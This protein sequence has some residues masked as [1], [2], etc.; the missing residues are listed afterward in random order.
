[1]IGASVAHGSWGFNVRNNQP[2]RP[3]FPF[4]F[5]AQKIRGGISCQK[6]LYLVYFHNGPAGSDGGF[7]WP[8]GGRGRVI[9]GKTTF[10]PPQSPETCPS[11][12][13]KNCVLGCCVSHEPGGGAGEAGLEAPCWQSRERI[14]DRVEESVAQFLPGLSVAGIAGWRPFPRDKVRRFTPGLS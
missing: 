6:T 1:M 3:G 7:T 9:P 2:S 4:S 14:W 13:P 10:H 12:R 5:Q 8:M 11:P